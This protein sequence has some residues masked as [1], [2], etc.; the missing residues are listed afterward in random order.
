MHVCGKLHYLIFRLNGP[1]I[2]WGGGG[3]NVCKRHLF[4]V[5]LRKLCFRIGKHHLKTYKHQSSTSEILMECKT[6]SN[7][8]SQQS[9]LMEDCISRLHIRTKEGSQPL[10]KSMLPTHVCVSHSWTSLVYFQ[11]LNCLLLLFTTLHR[12]NVK[13]LEFIGGSAAAQDTRTLHRN[14]CFIF[15][16]SDRRFQCSARTDIKV[17]FKMLKVLWPAILFDEHGLL[18]L[19]QKISK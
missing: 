2:I 8:S 16:V 9:I 19:I 3:G 13:F 12:A 4:V 15:P 7:R 11:H 6:N 5:L 18:F 10:K 14:H 17:I 1:L